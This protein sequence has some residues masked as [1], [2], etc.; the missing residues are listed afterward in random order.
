MITVIVL[1]VAV[2]VPSPSVTTYVVAPCAFQRGKGGEITHNDGVGSNRPS[3]GR[4]LR[5]E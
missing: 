4:R 3:P 5:R 2:G 1:H